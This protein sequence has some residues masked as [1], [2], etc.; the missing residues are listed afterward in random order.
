[1]VKPID[2]VRLYRLNDF[3][4]TSAYLEMRV[5]PDACGVSTR[6]PMW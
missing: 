2:A 6:I 3:G 1:M 4:P 5:E